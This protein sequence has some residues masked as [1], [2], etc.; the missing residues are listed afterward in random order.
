[1]RCLRPQLR[2]G[3][4]GTATCGVLQEC[5]A[6]AA[7]A[8][9]SFSTHHAGR[10]APTTTR[11]C[12]PPTHPAA[13][14]AVGNPTAGPCT[15]CRSAGAPTCCWAPRSS[16]PLGEGGSSSSS[17]VSAQPDAVCTPAGACVPPPRHTRFALSRDVLCKPP[18]PREADPL[19]ARPPLHDAGR[20]SGWKT[21]PTMWAAWMQRGWPC[22][23]PPRTGWSLRRR[24]PP[25]RSPSG[26]SR[27][28]ALR[29]AAEQWVAATPRCVAGWDVG[30]GVP[31]CHS[32]HC[33]MQATR[34]PTCIA[35]QR[36]HPLALLPLQVL[37]LSQ[38]TYPYPDIFVD[39]AGY[40][41]GEPCAAFRL[42]R[43]VLAA[44]WPAL[45]RVACCPCA[46]WHSTRPTAPP[47]SPAATPT[48][49]MG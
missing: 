41:Y 5:A 49:P 35:A 30:P 6:P 4:S 12:N 28:A 31:H 44:R 40:N 29:C 42:V 9:N 36:T 17:R 33:R 26:P 32:F 7:W 13:G 37:D 10:P 14:L 20:C 48:C 45:S 23:A 24:H 2:A 25:T 43:A 3:G 21:R 16:K 27:C 22:R 19:P 8:C 39:T 34:A 11:L 46:A 1:M 15:H 47:C 38:V 18:Q